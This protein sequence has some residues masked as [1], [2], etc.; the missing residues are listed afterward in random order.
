MHNTISIIS[1]AILLLL[2]AGTCNNKNNT[3]AD[4]KAPCI[5]GYVISPNGNQYD[6]YTQAQDTLHLIWELENNQKTKNLQTDVQPDDYLE[7]CGA[8]EER[9]E[10]LSI[11]GSDYQITTYPAS[12]YL[13]VRHAEKATP[14]GNTNLSPA[15][16]ARADLLAQ[17]YGSIAFD[18]ALTTRFCRTT[19]TAQPL[20]QSQS[21]PLYVQS[22]PNT[23]GNLT[24][25]D[26]G[27]ATPFELLPDS[28]SEMADID[29]YL[30][31][32]HPAGNILIAGH[33][34]TIP[35]WAGYLLGASVCPEIL[36]FTEEGQCYI[37]EDEY[38]H[39]FVI[40]R[41]REAGFGVMDVALSSR[42][43]LP[44]MRNASL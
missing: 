40:R 26:P 27:L 20:V 25:C 14:E 32:R 11:T 22:F 3:Q 36:A 18:A 31:S 34:N 33:S 10:L 2:Y 17:T 42:E 35:A 12:M 16:L 41:A 7:V 38:N 8:F 30:Q 4:R 21:L 9:G 44:H 39:V 13:L 5:T 6:V 19:Q 43:R 23:E 37:A 29:A 1:S 28:L 15:G 24:A